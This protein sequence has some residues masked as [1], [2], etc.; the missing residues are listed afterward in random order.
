MSG[1]M[2]RPAT[3]TRHTVDFTVDIDQR[4]FPR[5]QARPVRG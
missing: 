5:R 2:H 3:T 1:I 4:R